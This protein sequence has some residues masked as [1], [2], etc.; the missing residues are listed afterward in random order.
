MKYCTFCQSTRM[1][2]EDPNDECFEC[3]KRPK[4]ES[5]ESVFGKADEVKDL[6]DLLWIKWK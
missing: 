2:D 3:R 6:F 5:N 4:K 1:S